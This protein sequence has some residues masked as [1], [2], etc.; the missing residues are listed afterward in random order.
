MCL[1]SKLWVDRNVKIFP[2]V[3]DRTIYMDPAITCGSSFFLP[4]IVK[5]QFIMLSLGKVEQIIE[6]GFSSKTW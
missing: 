5:E 1:F 6:A 3:A 4:A 2:K